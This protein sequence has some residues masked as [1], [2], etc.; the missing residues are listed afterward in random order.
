[1]GLRP[2]APDNTP[3]LGRS[4][5]I[6]GLVWATGHHRNGILL[7]SITGELVA[8]VLTRTQPGVPA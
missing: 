2:G 7:A 5:Q 4:A 8:D 3:I 6:D 1:M